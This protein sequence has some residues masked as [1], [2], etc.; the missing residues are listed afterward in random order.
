MAHYKALLKGFNNMAMA[1]HKVSRFTSDEVDR[2]RDKIVYLV[3]EE[4]PFEKI[5]RK[6]ALEQNHMNA[7][8]YPDAGHGL[9]HELA[10]EINKK[11]VSVLLEKNEQEKTVLE[12]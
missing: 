5:G 7:V 8:F 1:W 10:E 6:A 2:I 3:G 9:N 11:I 12:K 4:D